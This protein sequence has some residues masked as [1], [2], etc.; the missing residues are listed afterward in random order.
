MTTYPYFILRTS[1]AG[2][3]K[4]FR[5]ILSGYAKVLEKMQSIN[6]TIDGSLDVATGSVQT[7]YM[8]LVRVRET[9]TEE[10]Y[11]D[12]ADLEMFYSLNNPN[13]TPSNLITFIDHF[14]N[15]H[16]V[17]MSGDFNSQLQGIMI[18]GDTAWSVVNC[19]FQIINQVEGS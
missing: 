7:K 6:R 14:G 15:Q 18:E 5:V 8:F 3:E 4:R 10:D 11:G 16:I 13:G 17:I 19:T 2:I 9:E 12:L 1:D